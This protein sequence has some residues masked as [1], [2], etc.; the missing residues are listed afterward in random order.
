MATQNEAMA[1]S[2]VDGAVL[3][4]TRPQSSESSTS[5]YSAWLE[6][7]I[8]VRDRALRLADERAT[9]DERMSPSA[10]ARDYAAETEKLFELTRRLLQSAR[11]DSDL[12][13]GPA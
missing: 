7:A 1:P 8:K 9:G 10:A 3:I 6:Q 2:Q 11:S 12:S 5:D 13:N 4:G